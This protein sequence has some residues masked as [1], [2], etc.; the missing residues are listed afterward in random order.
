MKLKKQLWM[1][2]LLGLVLVA[3]G[4][5]NLKQ[6]ETVTIAAEQ[7]QAL[8]VIDRLSFGVAP[9][10]LAKVQSQGI[11]KYIAAQLNPASI[12]ESPELQ[13][14]LKQFKTLTMNPVDLYKEYAP[15]QERRGEGTQRTQNNS[16]NRNNN[17]NNRNKQTE[18]NNNNNDLEQRIKKA[19]LRLRGVQVEAQQAHLLRSITSKRQLQEV[20][21]D[22]WYNHFNA[23]VQKGYYARMMAGNYSEKAIR[24][25]VF[26]NFRDILEA[27]ARHPMMLH[28]LDNWLNTDPNSKGAKGRYKG[29]NE[30][31]ARELM[32]LHTLGVDG[33]YTQAD[34]QALAKI[35]T[36]WGLDREGRKGTTDAFYFDKNRHDFSDKVLLGKTIKGTGEQE[37]E[38]ALDLLATHPSTA[39]HISY[40]LAQYF[41]ADK[42]PEALVEKLKQSFLQSKG[43]TKTV[44]ETLFN[45]PEFLDPQYYNKKFRTPYQ[46][47]VALSR[48][49]G[50]TSPNYPPIFATLAD[51]GMPI[52]SCVTPDGYKNTKEAWL[53]PDGM[54]RRLNLATTVANGRHN[55]NK[56]IDSQKL[57]QTLGN[58]FSAATEKAIAESSK[59]LRS[60]LILGSP[61]MMYR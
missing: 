19:R 55:N 40:K 35:L 22:F 61:E 41:I 34:V 56:A 4:C 32:E 11:K 5:F 50:D 38:Q 43:N 18:R 26:G 30:N 48:A 20:M 15:M 37:V 7:P 17:R 39:R 47:V 24:P 8:H 42:P 58:K 59:K 49:T 9:E 13:Q 45:S 57:T 53:N 23:N 14:K 29:I 44:L 33:G 46:Y 54:L 31:Y 21:V 10:E 36:G 1:T 3:F 52:F 16:E 28:Y 25:Y 27:T 12:S 6:S 2:L 51:M 60:A